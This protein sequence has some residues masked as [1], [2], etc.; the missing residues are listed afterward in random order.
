MVSNSGSS[1]V[2]HCFAFLSEGIR[3]W[4]ARYSKALGKCP[5]NYTNPL[6][7]NVDFNN[8]RILIHP[9]DL[10][11]E[12]DM[13]Y[14]SR[15]RTMPE[16]HTA[17][18]AIPRQT[19]SLTLTSRSRHAVLAML[20]LARH[21]QQGADQKPLSLA[22]IARAGGISLSYM[23]QLFSGL[24]RH[25][26]V[27]STRGPG[28]GYRLARAANSITIDEIFIA[29]EDII[30]ARRTH[31]EQEDDI[32]DAETAHLWEHIGRVLYQSLSKITLH[33]VLERNINDF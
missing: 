32:S 16:H 30:P 12:M 20:A 18:G 33:D 22:E 25:G 6:K 7:Q 26:L 3:I 10:G 28:G 8:F 9:H 29:A 2:L 23:E 21:V 5:K 15:D 24:R 31:K 4:S 27:K 17:G 1:A 14:Q 13:Y 19:R 11:V